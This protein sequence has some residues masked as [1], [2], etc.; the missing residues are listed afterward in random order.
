MCETRRSNGGLVSVIAADLLGHGPLAG[1]PDAELAAPTTLLILGGANPARWIIS[2]FALGSKEYVGT[3]A[4]LCACLCLYKLSGQVF[5]TWV[6][7]RN[8][9][10]STTSLLFVPD[11]EKQCYSINEPLHSTRFGAKGS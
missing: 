11:R 9:I 6:A 3:R 8:E 10:H 7:I 5:T 1:E 4:K 2:L